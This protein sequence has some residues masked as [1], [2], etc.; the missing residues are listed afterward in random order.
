MVPLAQALQVTHAVVVVGKDVVDLIS[1]SAT[2]APVFQE[3]LAL[4]SITSANRKSQLLPVRGKPRL[5]VTG[6]PAG[7]RHYLIPHYSSESAGAT[8]STTR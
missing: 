6:V 5:A 2:Q 1:W 4:P 7:A 3:L 8:S